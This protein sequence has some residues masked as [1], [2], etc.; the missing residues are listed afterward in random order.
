[1]EFFQ[2]GHFSSDSETQHCSLVNVGLHF[3]PPNLQN[4]VQKNK[5]TMFL[6][7]DKE[8]V[9]NKNQENYIKVNSLVHLG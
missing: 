5:Y 4:E 6:A 7:R 1:M 2:K 3:V 8:Q 9:M